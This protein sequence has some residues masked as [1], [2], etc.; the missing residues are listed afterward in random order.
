MSVQS[1]EL[2]GIVAHRECVQAGDAM[3]DVHKR[4]AK[5]GFE[6]MAVLDDD[7]LV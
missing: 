6:Y 2:R 1:A 5:H 4:F 7:K 3:E